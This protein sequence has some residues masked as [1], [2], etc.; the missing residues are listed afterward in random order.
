MICY[1]DRT[2]CVASGTRCINENCSRFLSESEGIR[3]Q[4]MNLPIAYSDFS[5]GCNKI[6]HLTMSTNN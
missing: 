6:V 3:A 5:D 4:K 2:Y 1:R